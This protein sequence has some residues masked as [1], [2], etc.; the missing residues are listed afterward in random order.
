MIVSYKLK[1]LLL[2][3]KAELC[4]LMLS[5][6]SWIYTCANPTEYWC[7]WRR[8]MP[9][10]KSLVIALIK[11]LLKSSA[12]L[13]CAFKD[14]F[15]YANLATLSSIL[16]YSL[17]WLFCFSTSSSSVLIVYLCLSSMSSIYDTFSWSAKLSFLKSPS[18]WW[19]PEVC[20]SFSMVSFKGGDDITN[21]SITTGECFSI[22]SFL[23]DDLF[24]ILY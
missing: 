17:S 12:S 10:S 8:L 9:S 23:V 5:C 4:R 6:N 13:R 14:S 2:A 15:C 7:F 18:Y 21:L 20:V 24:G 19:A 11:A 1:T 3:L 22:T 16:S